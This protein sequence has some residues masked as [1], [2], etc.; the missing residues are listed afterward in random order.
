MATFDHEKLDVYRL[1]M[2]FL[3]FADQVALRLTGKRYYMA[4]QLRRAAFSICLNIAEG[5]AEFSKPEKRRFY[6]MARRSTIECVAVIRA[7]ERLR[8]QLPPETP[9]NLDIA[10]R[11]T[12]M[13]TVMSKGPL[14]RPPS[15]SVSASVR[16]TNRSRSRTAG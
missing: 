11:I 12:A 7:C 5:A 2:D 10:W 13:L 14:K 1:S 4:N 15:A 16:S 9:A 3:V 8:I 6:R